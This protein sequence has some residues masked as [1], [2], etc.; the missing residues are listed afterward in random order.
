VSN[1][2]K[3]KLAPKNFFILE[4]TGVFQDTPSIP[5]ERVAQMMRLDG[6]RFVRAM[7]ENS[8]NRFQNLEKK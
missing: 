6:L 4:S 1:S 8:G 2:G 3:K 5:K 7:L